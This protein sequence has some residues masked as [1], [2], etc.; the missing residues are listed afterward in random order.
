MGSSSTK[1]CARRREIVV[2]RL[3]KAALARPVAFMRGNPLPR[4][5]QIAELSRVLMGPGVD[6]GGGRRGRADSSGRL[7]PT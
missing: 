4:N 2:Q 7:G 3:V 1:S 6:G 5:D